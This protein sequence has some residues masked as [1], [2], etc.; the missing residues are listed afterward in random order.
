[1]VFY[2]VIVSK[3]KDWHMALTLSSQSLMVNVEQILEELASIGNCSLK[4]FPLF[5]Y[6]TFYLRQQDISSYLHGRR[7][8]LCFCT[9]PCELSHLIHYTE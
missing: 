8:K 2:G 4:P 7:F 6:L 5:F 1:M 3:C 9:S